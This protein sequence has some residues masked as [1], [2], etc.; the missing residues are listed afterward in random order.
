MRDLFPVPSP[1]DGLCLKPESLFGQLKFGNIKPSPS[2]TRFDD[3]AEILG[4]I[5][6]G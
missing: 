5:E 3:R 1:L 6:T 4:Q 2:A